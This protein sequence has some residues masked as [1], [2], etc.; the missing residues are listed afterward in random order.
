MIAML[1][2]VAITVRHQGGANT[3]MTVCA[4]MHGGRVW[5]NA[6]NACGSEICAT[7]E[8]GAA[9]GVAL[10]LAPLRHLRHPLYRVVKVERRSAHGCMPDDVGA[11]I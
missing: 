5:R 2:M 8:G 9:Q 11:F 6:R 1:A 7:C 3:E 10:E 4:T